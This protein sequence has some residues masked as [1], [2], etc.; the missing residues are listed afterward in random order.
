MDIALFSN[1]LHAFRAQG[2]IRGQDRRKTCAANIQAVQRRP[3]TEN[4]IKHNVGLLAVTGNTWPK[5]STNVTFLAWFPNDSATTTRSSLGVSPVSKHQH[6]KRHVTHVEAAPR[7]N[8][9][10][11]KPS[12]NQLRIFHYPLPEQF[13][14]TTIFS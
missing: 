4:E 13:I 6:N 7:G 12:G 11:D 10:F 8:L 5:R 1:A 9:P 2:L 3:I 14:S